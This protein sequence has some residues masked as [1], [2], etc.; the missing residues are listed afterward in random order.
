[1]MNIPVIDLHCDALLRLYEHSYNFTNSPMLDVNLEKLQQGYVKAQAFAIFIDPDLPQERKL[2]AALKQ[3]Y[4]FQH[5]VISERVIHIKKWSDFKYLQPGQI[6]AFL[7]SEGVDFFGG[8]IE[9]WHQFQKFGVLAI[10]LTWNLANEAADGLQSYLGRGVTLF[11]KQ[12]ISLNNRHKIFTDVT[13]LNEQSFW[14]VM[15]YADYVIASH[16]NAKS[17]C[18]HPRNLNDAQI[19]AMIEKNAPIHVVYYP[20]FTTGTTNATMQ[21]LLRHV[22]YI[23]SMGGKHLIGIGSDFDGIDHKIVGLEHAGM[24]QNFMNELLKHYSEADV[25]GFAYENFLN[26]VPN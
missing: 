12:I 6:G 25:R 26:H 20:E 22:D 2:A 7:T 14:D 4:Y 8:N 13:H 9:I 15:E 17:V 21:D 19:K 24:H 16:S 5:H 11:G 10:G 3:V 23:C 1:M 18:N